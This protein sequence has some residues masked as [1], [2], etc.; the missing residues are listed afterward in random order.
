VFAPV[1]HYAFVDF[2]DAVY[3]LQNCHV[4]TGLTWANVTWAC[5]SLH[6]G[7][8]IPLVWLSYMADIRMSG[9]DPG[10]LHVTNLLLHLA[11]TLLL[12]DLLYRLTRAAGRSGLVAA[13]FAVHPLHVESVAWITERK[14]VL[15]TL[16]WLLAMH[17]YLGWVKKPTWKRQAVLLV[18]FALGLTAKPML[19]TLPIALLLLDVWPLGRLT[20]PD[21]RGPSLAALP[22]L[23]REKI[24]M[25]VLAA[26]ASCVTVVAQQGG[27]AVVDASR[28]PWSERAANALVSYAAYVGQMWWPTRLVALYPY[29]SL[30]T[31]SVLGA[32]LGLAGVTVLAIRG[33]RRCPYLLVGWLWYVLTLLPVIGLVQ[34][35]VQARADRFT[36]V[37][38]IGLF[39]VVAW[40][41]PD[42][43]ARWRLPRLLLP[44]VASLIVVL[45][46]LTARQQVRTWRNAM[47]LWQHA[48]DV[49]P[50]NYYAHTRLG[51]LHLADGRTNEAVEQ[52]AEALRIA[53]QYAEAHYGFGVALDQQGH[54]EAAI[55]QY[56]DALLAQPG[57]TEA[58][59]N[60]GVD[61]ATVGRVDDAFAQFTEA[62]RIDP[63]VAETHDNL[64]VL[65]AAE[66]REEEAT[67]QFLEA[68]RL[69]PEAEAAR[70]HLGQA[71]ARA[72]RVDEARAQFQDVLR[73]NPHHE[74]AAHALA[75]LDGRTGHSGR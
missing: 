40:G 13:L 36:Y 33:A 48:V 28:L 43:V 20:G 55:V 62:L 56:T 68:V 4:T 67:A 18:L 32:A 42:L 5:T 63:R 60:L 49:M 11:N 10:A 75:D 23:V 24:P 53:P 6:A 69:Q 17:A 1:R 3:V 57:L 9:L 61:L 19:V 27:G 74:G 14:D 73:I 72:G 38:L 45:C 44:A 39:V 41:V 34:V 31:W 22:A 50:E 59:N 29:S 64:G 15:S 37:P 46:A 7:Y 25:L 26:M 70:F 65:L 52:F 66:H 51:T 35:G 71:L 12:F 2:D 8:W 16:F 54:L 30:N 21:G 58:R 47:A